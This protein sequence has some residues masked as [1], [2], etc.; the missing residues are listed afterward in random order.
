M[1]IV[2]KGGVVRRDDRIGV[3]IPRR[4]HRTLDPV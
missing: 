3:I 2:G 4:P 1:A